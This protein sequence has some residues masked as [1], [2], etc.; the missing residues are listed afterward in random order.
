M[1]TTTT[2]TTTTTNRVS[3]Y[4]LSYALLM[5]GRVLVQAKATKALVMLDLPVW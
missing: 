5:Q 3:C 1:T 4:Q 2:T